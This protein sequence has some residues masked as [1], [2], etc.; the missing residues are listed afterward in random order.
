ME[1]R[2]FGQWKSQR[3]EKSASPILDYVKKL[4]LD[5]PKVIIIMGRAGTGK[6]TLIKEIKKN[7]NKKCASIAPTGISAYNINGSTIHSFFRYPP[8]P[9]PKEDFLNDS[10]KAVIRNLEVLII[11]EISMVNASVLDS[12]DNSL[13]RYKKTDKPFGGINLILVGDIFQLE[14]VNEEAVKEKYGETFFFLANSLEN[15]APKKFLLTRSFR[16]EEDQYKDKLLELLD[17]IRRGR[18]LDDTCRNINEIAFDPNYDKSK[19][20]MILTSTNQASENINL[21]F[22]KKLNTKEYTFKGIFSGKFS[23]ETKNLPAPSELTIKEGAQIVMTKNDA[24]N[25]FNGS[26]GTIKNIFDNSIEVK[27]GNSSYEVGRASWQRLKYKY[28]K[29]KDAIEETVLGSFEQFPIR[30]GWATTVHKS[31]GL[32]LDSVYIDLGDKAFA[33]GQTYVALSRSKTLKGIKLARPLT[34]ADVIVN[35]MIEEFYKDFY[36]QN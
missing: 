9:F 28:N 5:D 8:K 29:K 17:D 23:S 21:S 31:Q 34:P 10:T 19:S 27:I 33:S 36:L 11:D 26:V 3:V 16:H 7:S 30:L 32:T 25:W 20:Q 14:P 18:N 1:K 4:S 15:I 13:K 24:P 12:I 2:T 35:P 6:S 22:L